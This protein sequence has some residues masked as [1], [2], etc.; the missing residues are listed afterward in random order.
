MNTTPNANRIHITFIGKTNS[1]KSSLMNAIIGQD[2]SIVSPIEGTTTDPVSKAMEFIPL[3][4]VLF[5]D[6]AGLEDN[7]KLGKIRIEKT[8]NTLLRTDFAVYVMSAEDIDINL[9][10]KTINKFK[11]QNISYITVI[12]KMDIIEKNKIDNIKNII[13]DPIFVS[14][15]DINS[16]LN[17][18][19]LIIK[20]LSKTK[21]DHTI[22]GNLLPYNSKVIMVIPIDSEAPKGRLILP[23]VQLIRDCL[24]HGIKSYVVRDTELKSALD[25]LKNVDLVITDSQA[26]KKVNNIVR[27]NIKLTS[28]SILLANYKGNLKTFV[29]GTKAINSLNENS[30]ILISESCTHNFSHEDIGRVKIPNM[31]N[32]HVDKKLNYEFKMGE[33]FPQDV[34]KY[35]LIIHCGACMVNKKS[36]DSKLKLCI[37][38]NVPITN[39]GI[40]ISYLTGILDRSI[41]VFN[42]K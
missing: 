8:L 7:T 17:L 1:G 32:S 35:D 37:E 25:D 21:E 41:E 36:M 30:K 24:D 19:D 39:Y 34:D 40:L 20:N 12:N 14:S 18:K 15:N 29:E 3:G 6:T 10:E 28:F 23:Q 31:I 22:I 5:T 4:P 13:E 33:S 16:I 11:K 9:Y 26:F 2:I 38:K 42:I 27:K